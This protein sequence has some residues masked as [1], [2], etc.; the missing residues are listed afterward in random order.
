L[1]KNL[2]GE[3]NEAPQATNKVESSGNTNK[4]NGNEQ[5]TGVKPSENKDNADEKVVSNSDGETFVMV[6]CGYY[7][8][9]E[10]A[11]SIKNQLS[12]KVIAVNV[13][14]GDKF[15]VIAYIGT[16]DSANKLAEELTTADI[17]NTKARFFIPK[18]DTCNAEIIEII[19]GYLKILDKLKE[20]D[21]KGVKTQEFKEWVNKLEEKSDA[22]NYSIFKELKDGINSLPEEINKDNIEEGYQVVFKVINYFKI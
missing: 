9:K 8:K 21:V 6:Q 20:K 14:E 3:G 2:K 10:G 18:T 15:R 13:P 22:K 17:S 11:D 16:E 12:D 19:N 7:S 4:E 1:F 5:L